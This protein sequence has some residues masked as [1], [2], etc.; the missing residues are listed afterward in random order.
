MEA[1]IV[2]L[3]TLQR[4][5]R[6]VKFSKRAGD[7]VTLRELFEETGVDVARYFFL[8]RRADAQMIFD[9]D[10][11]LERSEKNPVYRIQYAHARMCSIFRKA[12]VDAEAL[13]VEGTELTPLRS[14][15]ELEVA[16]ALVDF[17][18]TVEAAALSREP[19]RLAAYLEQVA[20]LVNRWYHEGNRDP[21]LRVVG[22]D[23]PTQAAR[24]VFARAIQVVL[25]NGLTILGIGAP[26]HMERTEEEP[27]A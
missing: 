13:D 16:K 25:R 19:H 15:S 18:E 4:S 9:L 12:G 3:I 1:Q 2:Q 17:P 7:Y 10:L 5:G 20:N 26:E 23:P 6:D 22:V 14:P 21:S 8:N 24:L 11:A 27:E